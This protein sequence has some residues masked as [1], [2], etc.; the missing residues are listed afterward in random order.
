MPEVADRHG[1]SQVT[2]KSLAVLGIQHT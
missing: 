2:T 1:E